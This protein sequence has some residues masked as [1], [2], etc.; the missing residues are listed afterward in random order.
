M[1]QVVPCGLIQRRHK[2]RIPL[3]SGNNQILDLV[4]LYICLY[5]K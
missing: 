5:S 3:R 1:N 4:L 2:D